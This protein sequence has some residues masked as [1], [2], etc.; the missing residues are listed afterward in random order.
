MVADDGSDDGT[1]AMAARSTPFRCGPGAR[2]G[3]PCRRPERGAMPCRRPLLPPSRRR[4]D[5]LAGADRGPYRGEAEARPR[6]GSGH[7]QQPMARRLV[8]QAYVRGWSDHYAELATARR[9]GTTATGPT[10]PSRPDPPEIGGISTDLPPPKTSTWPSGSSGRAA[11]RASCRA[12]TAST[13][14]A[15]R[16]AT[17]SWPMPSAQ[18]SMHVEL[19][20]ASPRPRRTCS[21]G[22][23]RRATQLALRRAP[24]PF[25][26][27]P[28]PWLR[29]G[30]L[31]PATGRKMIWLH[32]VRRFA[33]WRGVRGSLGS[34][35]WGGHPAGSIE[36]D[37]GGAAMNG[38][39]HG[40]SI[41]IATHNRREL[42]R[43]C[44]GALA[45]RQPT[46]PLR[47]VVADDGSTTTARRWWRR[48]TRRSGPAALKLASTASPAPERRDR[49]RSGRICL[50]LDD[51]VIASRSLVS[52]PTTR[53][54]ART[55]GRSASGLI[56]QQPPDRQRLVA[57]T[58]PAAGPTLRGSRRPRGDLD[59]L[60]RRQP[61]APLHQLEQSAA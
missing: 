38:Q 58:L 34:H 17:G 29:L 45:S 36:A 20:D 50:I 16:E 55:R 23:R 51:D 37:D 39:G 6:S 18:G 7:D 33:F 35:S 48:S 56:V 21:T 9:T 40:L 14:T 26:S 57:R 15:R 3:R 10:S 54:T 1:A 31:I 2:E 44:L 13:T 32:F 28:P 11:R 12:P 41:L 49:G 60:L 43:R 52:E 22:R 46:R 8:A 42:L 47:G 25:V 27:P 19:S 59:R 61:L 4:H 53:P 30:G 5:R 24:S